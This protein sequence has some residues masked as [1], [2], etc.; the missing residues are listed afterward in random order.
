MREPAA[1][2]DTY[3][4]MIRADLG[5]RKV[6]I[7]GSVLNYNRVIGIANMLGIV[8]LRSVRSLP[9]ARIAIISRGIDSLAFGRRT[10]QREKRLTHLIVAGLDRITCRRIDNRDITDR[11]RVTVNRLNI[12]F[13]ADRSDREAPIIRAVDQDLAPVLILRMPVRGRDPLAR[14]QVAFA[15]Y[16]FGSPQNP[17]GASVDPQVGILTHARPR[18]RRAHVNRARATVALPLALI[19][20]RVGNERRAV[21]CEI[22]HARQSYR[23][24]RPYANGVPRSV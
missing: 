2:G 15:Q 9:N 14:A 22:P 4:N 13:I 21:S 11:Y 10:D 5:P 23:G 1:L 24:L 6:G 16:L 8:R 19:G 18:E 20:P 17:R 12:D 7:I 3:R